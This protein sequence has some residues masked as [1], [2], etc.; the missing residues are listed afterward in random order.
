MYAPLDR[1]PGLAGTGDGI[2]VIAHGI[3]ML[4]AA[5][6][7]QL[8]SD[9]SDGTLLSASIDVTTPMLMLEIPAAARPLLQLLPHSE[10]RV[11]LVMLPS[12]SLKRLH[13][14]SCQLAAPLVQ[15]PPFHTHARAPTTSSPRPPSSALLSNKN[16]SSLTDK[17]RNASNLSQKGSCAAE[18]RLTNM[19]HLD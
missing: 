14:I 7:S 3:P 1:F 18:N 6:A 10:S 16:L 17:K 19:I 13:S 2:A 5:A 15:R 11:T 4:D 12:F 9:G 8:S